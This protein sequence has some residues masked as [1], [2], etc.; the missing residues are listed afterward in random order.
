M[1]PIQ[2]A[3]DLD[4]LSRDYLLV[5]PITHEVVIRE[6]LSKKM[7]AIVLHIQKMMK[8]SMLRTW[9][10]LTGQFKSFFNKNSTIKKGDPSNFDRDKMI[11]FKCKKGYMKVGCPLLKKNNFKKKR[12]LHVLLEVT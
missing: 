2:E 6:N 5:Y 3:K 7:K 10:Y 8:K 1:I 11:C 12:W 4:T 9:I